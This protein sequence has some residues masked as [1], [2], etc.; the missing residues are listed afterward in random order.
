MRART[1]G[2]VLALVLVACSSSTAPP[3]SP[4]TGS[5]TGEAMG[6]TLDLKV[7]ESN[8]SVTGSGSFSGYVVS[9]P[10]TVSGSYYAN[11]VALT[12]TTPTG[13]IAHY[14]GKLV[15]PDELDGTVWLCD[16]NSGRCIGG[17][18]VNPF[19]LTLTKK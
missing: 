8:S 19:D 6:V 9:T 11:G 4:L 12:L 16:M 3:Q 18:Q 13:S 17:Y 5:W 2:P 1:M 15:P 14:N 7:T 10:L